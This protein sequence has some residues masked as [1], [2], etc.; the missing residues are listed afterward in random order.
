MEHSAPAV[1]LIRDR[2]DERLRLSAKEVKHI[3]ISFR[4]MYD[5]DCDRL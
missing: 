1:H 3:T 4:E 2:W 5:S